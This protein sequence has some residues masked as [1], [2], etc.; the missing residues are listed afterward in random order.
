MDEGAPLIPVSVPGAPPTGAVHRAGGR[1]PVRLVLFTLSAIVAVAFGFIANDAKSSLDYIQRFGYYGIAATFAWGVLACARVAPAWW[2]SLPAA[3]RGAR[4]Q[5]AAVIAACTL[6]A[7]LTV[8]YGYKVLY[9]EFVLQATALDLHLIREVG[10]L[11]RA[12]EIDG[13]FASL[14]AYLDK[15]PYFFAFVVSLLH[16][17]TG[18]RPANAFALN[19]VLLP[20]VLALLYTYARRLAGH[21]AALAATVALGTLSLL[22]HNATGAGMEMLNLTML[23]L[24]MHLAAFYLA[25]PDEPRLAALVLVCVLLA[26]TRYESSLYA[27]PVAVIVLAGWLRAGRIILPAAAVLGPVLLIPY[28]LH[29][30]YLSS[31]PILWELKDDAQTRFSLANYG[32]NLVHAW[33]YFFNFTRLLTN[34]WWLAGA[35]GLALLAAL[36]HALRALPHWR[37]A[38]PARMT[39]AIFGV[40]IAGNLLLLMFY[41]WGQLDD[42]IVARLSLPFC[43]LQALCL[44]WAVQTWSGPR[45]PL[46][47]VVAGGAVA[48]YLTCGL[49]ANARQS[50]LNVL[51]TELAWEQRM[52][53]ARPPAT[54]LIISNKSPLPW[55][56]QQ[57]GALQIDHA[58]FR[59]EQVK[60]HLDQHTFGEVLI[61]QT[62]RPVGASGGFQLDL[63]DRLPDA[64]VLEPVVERRFGVNLD[65]LSRVVAIRLPT[66]LAAAGP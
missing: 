43:V 27:A 38:A 2:R 3:P 62:Y 46:A 16:D 11:A 10:T 15:R 65:R 64:Y 54:R 55:F 37:T 12:Y 26:Q 57:I 22:A 58:R 24:A 33:N 30:T 53:E 1:L 63:R 41:Y 5:T 35:G 9:D 36:F 60:F 48:A 14:N 34:S 25:A 49:V 47:A 28:A 17:L 20:V 18:Y 59:A 40:A 7:V 13:S 51:G 21:G 52:V 8:P 42:P 61:F 56:V 66:A 44:A 6:I 31:T 50:D 29:N 19:T 32:D 4:W 45:R 39:L 23:L